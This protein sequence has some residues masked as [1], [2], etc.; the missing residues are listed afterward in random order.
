M[1]GGV[2]AAVVKRQTES[3]EA[4]QL[5]LKGRHYWQKWNEEGFA[6]S[7]ACMERAI[8]LDPGYALAYVGLAD[9]HLA[10]GAIGLISYE[11]LLPKAKD[12]LTRALSIDSELAEAWALMGVVHM[13]AW[14]WAAGLSASTR[15]IEL[16]PR[17]GHAYLVRALNY[18]YSGRAGEMLPDARRAV[19]F[20]PLMLMGH[21]S[22][23]LAF[24]ARRDY[25][26]AASQTD[27][28]LD[29]NPVFWW[30]H[31]CRGVIAVAREAYVAAGRCFEEAARYSGGAPYAAGLA[32]FASARA[33]EHEQAER[34]LAALLAHGRERHV[35]AIGIAL[36]YAGL[37][38][39]DRACEW[40]ERSFAERDIFLIVEVRYLRQLD[41]LR[42]DPRMD[43]LRR[44]LAAAGVRVDGE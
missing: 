34:G 28:L 5:Y 8:A 10:S 33:G 44:R 9:C 42:A 35:P 43:D 18:C 30:G 39:D 36:A 13:Q 11:A 29:I 3:I 22:I 23:I 41:G 37:G 32:V 38:Q 17:L 19:D 2:K 24:L 16:N 7:Q 12:A 20:D 4:Y 25:E 6:Q 40:L 1:L 21:F 14:D 27:A 26:A 31:Y 15:A